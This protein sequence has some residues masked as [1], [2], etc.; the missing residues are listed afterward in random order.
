[1]IPIQL[2]VLKLVKFMKK[3]NIFLTGSIDALKNWSPDNALA[4]SFTENSIWTSKHAH[5]VFKYV[6]NVF[7]FQVT[8]PLP[9]STNFE[10]KYIR[11]FNGAIT[12][13]SDPNNSQT[14]PASGSFTIKDTWR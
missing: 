2:R 12:W 3:E 8:V 6:L 14:T 9:P 1:L 7:F 10:Y 13:E 4:L 5:A 11:K